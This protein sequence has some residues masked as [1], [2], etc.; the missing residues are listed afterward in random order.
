MWVWWQAT[1]FN[2][3]RAETWCAPSR[4]AFMTGRYGWELGTHFPDQEM[5]SPD[6]MI[7]ASSVLRDAGYHTALVGK[8]HVTSS[9]A[10]QDRDWGQVAHYN[11]TATKTGD[12]QPGFNALKGKTGGFGCGFDDAYGFD[13]GESGYYKHSPHMQRNGEAHDDKGY[14]TDL[15]ADEATSIVKKHKKERGSQPLFLWMALNAPHP[16]FEAPANVV[17]RFTEAEVLKAAGGESQ[18]SDENYAAFRKHGSMGLT[19]TRTYLALVYIMDKAF[20]QVADA[21]SAAGMWSNTLSIFMSDNGGPYGTAPCNG[22][23]R[24]G[25][26]TP[27]DGGTRVPFFVHWPSALGSKARHTNAPGHIA[28]LLATFYDVAKGGITDAKVRGEL[29]S[30]ARRA[31][32]PRRAPPLSSHPPPSL[33]FLTPP[34]LPRLRLRRCRSLR[35]SRA[36]CSRPSAAPRPRRSCSG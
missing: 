13:G 15:F 30:K 19:Q 1:H 35:R 20:H 16:P 11:I 32:A 8:W 18:N 36:R 6:N 7:M 25:K 9:E 3:F 2:N 29:N 27:F 5:L 28:D 26:A 33:L 10:C 24:G 4:T 23:L 17:S 34:P 22:G 14:L 21:M 31:A 12:L